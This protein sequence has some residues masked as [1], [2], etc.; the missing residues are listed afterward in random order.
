MTAHPL[1][2]LSED[3]IREVARI[4]RRERE[5]TR[6]QWRIASIELVEPAKQLVREFRPGDP[7]ERRARVVLWSTETGSAYVAVLSLT[8]GNEAGEENTVESWQPQPG[9]QP[10]ATVDEWHDCDQAMRAHPE[11]LAALAKRGIDDPELVLVDVWTYGAHLIPEKYTG[12]R[13]GW[14]DLWLRAAPDSNPYAHPISGLK[15]VVDLNTM[16]L[17][18]IEDTPSAGFPPVQ[19]EYTPRHVPG[20]TAR[21]DLRPLEVSQPDGASFTLDGHLLSWQNWSLR[22]GFNYREGLVLHTVSYAGRP[23]ANRMSFAEMVVPYRD[24]TP[25]HVRRTAYDIGEWG[26][27]F[28]TTSLELGCDCLGEIRY[29]DA[30]MHDSKGEP[31]TI[32]NAV[33]IH[34][35]D[36]AVLWKHVDHDAGAEVRRMRRLTIS[37][38]V[39]VANYEYLVYWRLYQDGNIECEVRATGIMVTTPLAP[40]A[41]NPNG[42]LVDERTYAP[43]HQHF[44]VA[45]LDMDVD[46]GDNTVF[47]S[48]SYAE[49]MGPENPYGLSLVTRNVPLRTESEGK[50]DFNFDTQRAWKVINTNVTNGLGTHPAYKLVPGGAIPAMFDPASPVLKRAGVIGHTVWVTP[51]AADERWPAGEFVNQSVEDTG[52]GEWTKANRSIDNTDVV[53]WYVFGLHHI[54][55]PED[56]PVMPVDIVSFWLKP[57]GFFDR[58]PALDVPAAEP[59]ACHAKS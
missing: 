4:L 13:I 48:E 42:T 56:W 30:V 32:A 55:R 5:V 45:R 20:Y 14:C 1:D 28:M 34:E 52:L 43:F 9:R 44:L 23:V 19:G 38:H 46:G 12:L 53:L 50:Q 58:N 51:N 54:T 47:M 22:L 18:E 49:P 2:P 8:T 40:G 35:E 21:T 57:F 16:A 37:F 59:D 36:G 26:L 10:N 25:D 11:V 6:P 31:Y 3:E 15:L 41:P 7:I 24:P 29:L 33:C 27:G 17:L 39:T